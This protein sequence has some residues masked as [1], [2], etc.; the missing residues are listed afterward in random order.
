MAAAVLT[1]GSRGFQKEF[2]YELWKCEVIRTADVP[3]KERL[4]AALLER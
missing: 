3:G 4:W 1:N 2:L